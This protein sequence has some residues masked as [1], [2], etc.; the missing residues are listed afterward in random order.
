[1]TIFESY[2]DSFLGLVESGD[3]YLFLLPVYVTL[4]GG[5][6]L[7]Y[8]LRHAGE[9]NDRDA[10]TNI[11]ITV[12]QLCLNIAVGHFLPLAVMSIIFNHFSLLELDGSLIHWLLAFVLYDLAWYVDHRIAHRVGFFWSMHHVHHSSAEYNMTVASRGFII[13]ITLISRPTFYLLPIFGMAPHQFMIVVIFSNIWGIAQHTRLFP[14]QRLLD[15][16]FATP[17]NHRVHHGRNPKYIDRNYG[18]VLILWDR[19]FGTYQS[20]EE[21]SDYGVVTPVKTYH[22]IHVELAG[23]KWLIQKIQSTRRW[24][25]KLRCLYKPP[26]WTPPMSGMDKDFTIPT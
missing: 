23:L 1:M 15:G 2:A 25:D 9:W 12:I 14:K 22:P 18:E 3:T 17:S 13:D 21:E 20:E 26:E 5:E 24:S 11:F 7:V 4:I 19:V 10:A 6:R 16:L 8:L